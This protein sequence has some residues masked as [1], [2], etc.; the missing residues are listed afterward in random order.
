M[1]NKLD[2]KFCYFYYD[3][4]K[5]KKID[6]TLSLIRKAYLKNRKFYNKS[7]KKFKLIFLYSRKEMNKFWRERTSRWCIAFTRNKIYIFSPQIIEKVSIHK[8]EVF[9]NTLIHELN[10]MFYLKIFKTYKPLWISE[11]L[12]LNLESNKNQPRTIITYN[13]LYGL[14]LPFVFIGKKYNKRII[15]FSFLNYLT[16]K[17]LL[18]KY[19]RQRLFRLLNLYSRNPI[20]K[21]FIKSFNRIYGFPFN[22][23]TK[24]VL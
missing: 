7:I 6:K 10:H 18:D 15:D 19:G 4:N 14:S 24:R 12:A 9:F 5:E 16:I 22:S 11:G 8:K 17:Y 21:Y 23:L 3:A 13:N 1:R 20:K 2:L